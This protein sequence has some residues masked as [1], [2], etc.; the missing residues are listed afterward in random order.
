MFRSASARRCGLR[1]AAAAALAAAVLAPPPASAAAQEDPAKIRWAFQGELTSVLSHGN[2]EALTL[3]LGTVIRRQW[4][5]DALRFE[6]GAIRVETG[7]ITRK[8]VGTA[9]AFTVTRDVERTKTAEALFARGRYDRRISERVF[10]FGGVDWLRNTFAGIDSRLLMAAGGG[11]KLAAS[12][13]TRLSLRYAAT[14]TFQ[15]DVVK[16]PF[17]GTDF[18]G[19]RVAWE[20]WR[21]VSASTVFESAFTGDQNLRDTDDLRVDLTNALTV[22]VNDKLALK[23]SLQLLWRNRPSL[24][25]VPLYATDGSA[26]GAKVKAPLEE[27]D[28]FFRLALVLRL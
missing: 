1:L 2:S 23:P 28:T 14:Y 17:V 21:R 19:V 7:K 15:A 22:D 4:E 12:D 9:D 26:T 10:A 16:N 24:S 27:L 11:S 13:R 5:K 3:G 20:L 18:V 8:A 25:D 6:A